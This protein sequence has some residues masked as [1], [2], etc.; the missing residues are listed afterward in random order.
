MQ[1]QGFKLTYKDQGFKL[2]YKHIRKQV[3]RNTDTYIH[4]TMA[5]T[6]DSLAIQCLFGIYNISISLIITWVISTIHTF[7]G[8]EIELNQD[9][10]FD[11]GNGHLLFYNDGINYTYQPRKTLFIH[12][13]GHYC[14]A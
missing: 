5:T 13:C 1:N 12:N 14:S 2:T 9:V 8:Y 3:I 7:W 6:W 4:I 11:V 10:E